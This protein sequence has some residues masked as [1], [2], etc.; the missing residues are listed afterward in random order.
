MTAN[1][2]F[3]II[4]QVSGLLGIVGS[5]FAMG[6]GL[7]ISQIIQPLKNARLV[8]LVLLANFVLVPLLAYGITLVIPLEDSLRIGLIVLATCAGAP[9]LILEAKGAKASLAVAVGVM[10][11][12]MVVTI[13]YLPVV[14]P[15]LLTG[16]E[17]DAGAIAQ[18]LIVL[19]LIPL[20]L[21]LLIKAHAPD[22]AKN[23]APTMNKIG[24]LGILILLVVGLGLNLANVISL[25]G[26]RGFLALLLFIIGSLLIGF[27]FGGRDPGIRNVMVLG[28]AQRNVSAAILITLQNFAGTNAVPFVLAAAILIPLIL[29]SL[30]RWLG[31]QGESSVPVE[32]PAAPPAS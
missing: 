18:S 23:W 26:T 3:T 27:A 28:T 8:I 14:L 31:K 5:M 32:A 24:S 6:L 29:L 19:M 17:V 16:V 12:L 20:I 13:F 30:A 25:I 2:L 4:A 7:T 22:T 1:E 11:L 9:F 15:L 21:G 10:T